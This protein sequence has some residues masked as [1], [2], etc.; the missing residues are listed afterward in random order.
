M[1]SAGYVDWVWDWRRRKYVIAC[2]S[3]G[4]VEDNRPRISLRFRSCDVCTEASSLS[5]AFFW[6]LDKV[7]M[8]SLSLVDGRGMLTHFGIFSQ[9][10]SHATHVGDVSMCSLRSH[11]PIDA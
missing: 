2:V 11:S 8:G 7:N 1:D 5:L 4:C 9:C 6:A 3:K 10:V